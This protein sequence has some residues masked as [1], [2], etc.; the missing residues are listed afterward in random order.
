MSKKTTAGPSA[1]ADGAGA[2]NT[3]STATST[4]LEVGSDPNLAVNQDDQG[5]TGTADAGNQGVATGA[6]GDDDQVVTDW[7]ASLAYP[8]VTVLRNNGHTTIVEPETAQI[9]GGGGAVRV[10]LVDEGHAVRVLDN[11]VQLN[12]MHFQGELKVRLDAA[13][14]ELYLKG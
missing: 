2:N 13:P 5:V 7:A 1:S 6:L 12:A 14:D 4:L 3:E 9:V 10:T 11:T 8:V